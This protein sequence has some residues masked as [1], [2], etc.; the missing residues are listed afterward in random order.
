MTAPA[1]HDCPFCH[2]AGCP[3][4][5]GGEV[6]D[7]EIY[8]APTARGLYDGIDEAVYHGDRNSLSSSGARKLLPPYTP[9][10]FRWMQDNPREEKDYFDVGHAAHSLVLGVGAPIHEVRHDD[11]RSKA[12]KEERAECYDD[13]LTPL[14]TVDYQAVRAMA[15]AVRSHPLAAALLAHGVAEQSGYHRDPGTDVMLRFRPDWITE[16]RD[17]RRLIVDYK[18]SRSADPRLFV[19]SAAKFGYHQQH[20]WYTEGLQAVLE[21]EYEPDLLFIV[22]DKNPPYLVS[23]VGLEGHDIERGRDLNR[24]AIDI[25][26]ECVAT[27]E[28]PGHP[29]EIHYL[30]LPKWSAYQDEESL[31]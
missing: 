9:A 28:W 7:R 10:S 31:A 5:G 6:D 25:Y 24:R 13:G 27:G 8:K 16:T 2:G 29:N 15:A 14:L 23:V 26:A 21:L 17:G 11:W 19:A 20:P 4:C 18:T 12:A 3:H 22:Q 30:S 1:V